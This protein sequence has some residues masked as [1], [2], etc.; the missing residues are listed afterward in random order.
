MINAIDNILRFDCDLVDFVLLL[1]SLGSLFSRTLCEG[2]YIKLVSALRSRSSIIKGSKIYAHFAYCRRQV[3][4]YEHNIIT[5]T[6][7]LLNLFN[8]S[9]RLTCLDLFCA[10]FNYIL[11][12]VWPLSEYR[13][14]CRVCPKGELENCLMKS[15][16]Y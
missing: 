9:R 15:S 11:P 4:F 12:S 8:F 13:A 10:P 2:K 6:Q 14:S 5:S 1:N 16:L 3:Y 7:Y